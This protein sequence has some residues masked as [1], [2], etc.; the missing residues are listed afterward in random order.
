MAIHPEYTDNSVVGSGSSSSLSILASVSYPHT[1]KGKSLNSTPTLS[2]T[3]ATVTNGMVRTSNQT[4]ASAAYVY[5]LLGRVEA[6][7]R[8]RRFG[9]IVDRFRNFRS[10]YFTQTYRTVSPG[11]STVW[12]HYRGMDQ[13]VTQ[14]KDRFF[15]GYISKALEEV[16]RGLNKDLRRAETFFTDEEQHYATVA[17]R[18]AICWLKEFRP[19]FYPKPSVNDEGAVTLLWKG[20]DQSIACIFVGDGTI[21]YAVAKRFRSFGANLKFVDLKDAANLPIRRAIEIAAGRH[22]HE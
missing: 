2:S 15:V 8:V 5:R 7:S 14:I 22:R 4:S 10:P 18:E 11:F 21:A 19:Q 17:I 12:T 3:L 6:S 13:R 9:P 16:E 20:N 1:F